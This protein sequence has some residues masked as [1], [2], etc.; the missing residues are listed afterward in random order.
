M[1]VICFLLFI[2]SFL[3]SPVNAQ[4][5][6]LVLS[7][8]GAK[9]CAHIG[10]IRALEEGGVPIDYIAGTSI[11]A[12]IGSLYA[13]G[14]SPDEMEALILS[15]EFL[16]WQR[17]KIED[18]SIYYFKKNEPNP[19]FINIGIRITD[20][21]TFKT[22]FLPPSFIQ[23]LQMNFGFLKTFSQATSVCKNNFD[24][25]FVPFRCVAADVYQKEPVVHRSGDL[26]DAVRSSMTFPLVF[27]PIMVDGRLLF[28]GG[29]YDNFPVSVMETD[30]KP[31]YIIGSSV[32][33]NPSQPNESDMILQLENMI[34]SKT[35]YSISDEKGILL[36]FK[37]QD[38]GLL[39]FN[40]VLTL[41]KMG[42]DLTLS[43]MS[44]IKTAI[45]REV[46]PEHVE[47]K[48]KI[49]RSYLPN[50]V[51]KDIHII[52]V[53]STQ[54]AYIS[55]TFRH[56]DEYFTLESFR[57]NYFKLLSDKRFSEIIPH[58][59]FNEETNAY[60]LILDVKMD[61]NIRIG[62]GGN[63]SSST[64]NELYLGLG[65]Q[66]IY[67]FA[68]DL[69]LEGQI[70]LFYNNLHFQS[71]VCL[72]TYLPVYLKIIGNMHLF[73]YYRNQQPFYE[74][75]ISS[76]ASTYEVFS[77]I[78][79]GFPFLM[80]GKMEF[81]AGYGKIIDQY[82]GLYTSKENKDKT[83]Y[84]LAVFSAKFDQNS[85]V[86]K[87][88]PTSGS[89]A[90]VTAQ[91]ILGREYY[92]VYSWDAQD[93][94]KD[95]KSKGCSWLQ[96]SA[97][98]DQYFRLSKSFIL[99]GYAEGVHSTKR[100]GSNYME[101]M[102]QAPAFT[103]TNHSRTIYNPGYRANAYAAGGLKPI[104]KINN[105]IHLRLENYLYIPFRPIYPNNKFEPVYGD[106]LSKIEYMN[107]LSIV[108]HF[109]MLTISVYANNYSFPKG[110]WN[111]G[112]NIGFLLFNNKLV[113]K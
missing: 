58:A 70:G 23:P 5:V 44:E 43:K 103:P 85:F 51:F 10:V 33:S 102:L 105:Q 113:E 68:Y 54:K 89:A 31:D 13:M 69:L 111:L 46:K 81:G 40:K 108:A 47:L 35:N 12:I 50:L 4:K 66:G 19:E 84:N 6:G 65:Y 11:G 14:Y 36:D 56:K 106:I 109:N 98:Y 95:T 27:K 67:H 96:L 107:E 20:S 78:K 75:D 24:N 39:D 45:P 57:Q 63:I 9:G 15:D 93:L 76:E 97:V 87:Q 73:S 18:N 112:T 34:M 77:K 17:G 100:L 3:C 79:W 2:L 53:N 32:A 94:I 7:G 80:T 30:F 74:E 101:T 71:R 64:S 48:R 72:P 60:D 22:H 82:Y 110:N 28:D 41:S 59:V 8:G 1:R 62:I 86:Q 92:G 104:Y 61:E 52:G 37:F 90:S 88:Y 83:T 49:F 91:Y 21:L 42:Y 25:L 16:S 26:G 29:I 38:V 55:K 99:G